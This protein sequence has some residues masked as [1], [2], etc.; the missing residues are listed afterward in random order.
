[1][2]F[3]VLGAIKLTIWHKINLKAE[4]IKLFVY[5]CFKGIDKIQLN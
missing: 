5:E 4:K 3:M 2:V 1:M